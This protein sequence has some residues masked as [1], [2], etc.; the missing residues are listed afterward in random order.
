MC[1]WL[2]EEYKFLQIGGDRPYQKG[3][4]RSAVPKE[5]QRL[6]WHHPYQQFQQAE[7]SV[8]DVAR[9]AMHFNRRASSA[10]SGSLDCHLHSAGCGIRVLPDELDAITYG[11][12]SSAAMKPHVH[13]KSF[14]R[15]H[16]ASTSL[17]RPSTSKSYRGA[18]HKSSSLLALAGA[19]WQP[20]EYAFSFLNKLCCTGSGCISS[21]LRGVCGMMY[22]PS[23]GAYCGNLGSACDEA[24]Y[25]GYGW[26]GISGTLHDLSESAADGRHS[27]RPNRQTPAAPTV[28]AVPA[29]PPA[30][31]E[32][33]HKYTASLVSRGCKQLLDRDTQEAE[34]QSVTL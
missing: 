22:Q 18:E 20:S 33:K 13:K 27:P 16:S 26:Q 12:H 7:R 34:Q 25:I 30:P 6:S 8:V 2:A 31:K 32:Q 4:R 19:V 10:G 14:P 28:P 11:P 9:E 29:A 15:A 17:L 24:G 21:G 23:G 5:Q 3:N 1:L